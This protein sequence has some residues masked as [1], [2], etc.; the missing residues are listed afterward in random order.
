M[1]RTGIANLPLHGGKAPKWLFD[2]MVKLAEG[3]IELTVI[4]YGKDEFLNRV[5]DPFWFQALSCT[6]GFDWHSS[7]TTTVTCGAIKE[8]VKPNRLGLAVAGG[9]GKVSRRTPFEIETLGEGFNLSSSKQAELIYSSRM[10]AKI[11][12]TA[13]QDQH[14]LYHHNFIFTEEGKWAVIQ[15]GL[16]TNSR[17]ARRYHW[18]SD[19]VDEFVIEPHDAILGDQH[20]DKVLDMTSKESENA[21]KITVDL[22]NDDP[23]KLQNMVASPRPSFQR[24]IDDWIQDNDSDKQNVKVLTMPNTINWTR[25]RDAYEVQPKNFEELISIKGIGPATVRA[26][27][28]I[29]ELVYGESPSWKDPVKYSFTVGGKDGVPYPVDKKT[30]DRSIQILK[31]GVSEAKIG[32]KDKTNALQRLRKFVPQDI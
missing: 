6:L 10:S 27:A 15:Q 5:S 18:L 29:S 32:N 24:S 3:I 7:G 31:Q 25:L 28:L 1:P 4:E 30:M 11:D 2:R 17:Y 8:A 13:I 26:L 16:D 21:R 9:K 14:Q 20:L 23:R 19:N 12:N 22:V